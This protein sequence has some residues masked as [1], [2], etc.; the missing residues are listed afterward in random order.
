M[1]GRAYPCQITLV[2]C[3]VVLTGVVSFRK[4]LYRVVGNAALG[5]EAAGAS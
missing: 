3:P 4:E 2:H 1:I 5:Q